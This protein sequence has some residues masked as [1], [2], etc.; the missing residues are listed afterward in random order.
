MERGRAVF[1]TLVKHADSFSDLIELFDEWKGPGVL[2]PK[3]YGVLMFRALTE[4]QVQA[5]VTYI[6][7]ARIAVDE[8]FFK[9]LAR[10]PSFR[11]A[12]HGL[13]S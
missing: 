4:E 3:H 2:Q 1:T 6:L 9:A 12:L 10:G 7:E 11:V 8:K 5:A 13:P